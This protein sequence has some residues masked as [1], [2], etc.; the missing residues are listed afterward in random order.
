MFQVG[1]KKIDDLI[2]G[3]VDNLK[4]NKEVLSVVLFGSYA[5]GD[6]SLR[7]SD[8]DLYILFSGKRDSKVE[9]KLWRDLN[10]ISKDI[11]VHLNFEYSFLIKEGSLLRYNVF[12]EGVILFEREKVIFL[13]D[14]L[15]LTEVLLLKLNLSSLKA[16]QKSNLKRS[17]KLKYS[18]F[19][20]EYSGNLV[21]ISKDFLSKFEDILISREVSFEILREFMYREKKD[22]DN[23]E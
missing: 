17:I 2:Q 5:R 20:L 21:I 11:Q 10:Y 7:H 8:L 22:F 18:K 9:R 15:D 13:K 4:L 3:C 12:K 14:D 23:L 19:V 6:Y 16:N 1:I